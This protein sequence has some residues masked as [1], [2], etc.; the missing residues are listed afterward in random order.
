MKKLL[1]VLFGLLP[2][3]TPAVAQAQDCICTTNN[4]SLTI[5]GY[6]GAGGNVVLPTNINLL[7]VTSIG[8]DA[9]YNC[10]NLTGVTVPGTITNI[11]EDAFY[12]C[13]N[14]ASVTI[15]SNVTSIGNQA[16][17]VCPSLATITV[18]PQNLYYSS[19]NGVLFDYN[20][21]TLIQYPP[22]ESGAAYAIPGTVTNIGNWAFYNC[23]N[24]T[25]VG[26]PGGVASIGQS[27]FYNCPNLT[28][29]D[30][31]GSVTNIGNAA[32]AACF[33]MAAI[34]VKTPNPAYSSSNGV[35]FNYNMDTLFEYPSGKC[36]S[37]I[38][39]GG[40]TNIAQDAFLYAINLTAVTIP[41]SVT[42]I[43]FFA[44]E[45]CA[46]LTNIIIP[47]SVTNIGLDAFFYCTNLGS[48]F[49]T[50]NA[51]GIESYV[52]YGNNNATAYYLPSATGWTNSFAG[53][54]ALLWNPR[55]QTG[56]GSL[57]VRNNQFGFNIT[58]AT[59]I[60]VQVQV[61]TNLAHPVWVP[62]QTVTLTNGS[63]YFNDPQW[64]NYRV[65]FYGIGLP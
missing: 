51:P 49:F 34:T 32:F 10:T 36:G 5:V 21:D 55:I 58:G 42:G 12:Y 9:F 19:S 43:G 46:S 16:F 48:V 4:G 13:T 17:F 7:T 23:P 39:P 56:G 20:K 6:I 2:L 37:Y 27:A 63:C 40:V 11:G 59:N 14:L 64:T 57:G 47:G 61:C 38:I 24:L 35:L 45:D 28:N 41:N 31:P 3:A 15:S 44:F 8:A 52:F 53:L 1:L 50:G 30:I 65:R 18:D 29:I 62:L 54:P 26:I 33:N 22:A 60:P 25:N